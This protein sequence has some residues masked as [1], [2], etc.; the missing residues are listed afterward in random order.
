MGKIVITSGERYVDIDVLACAISYKDLL[1]QEGKDAIAVFPGTFNKSITNDIKE[2][3]V[4]YLKSCPDGVGGFVIVDM[5]NP[6][7]MAKCVIKDKIIQIYDHHFG[8]KEYWE[9]RL[10][11]N[12]V[13]EYVGSCATLIWE[14][15]KKRSNEDISEVNANLLSVAIVSNTLNFKASVTNERDRKALD[16]LKPHRALDDEWI[17]KYFK[18]QSEVVY[19]NPVREITNDSNLY[20][21]LEDF[22]V[23]TI[24]QIELWDSRKLV[25][26]Y[27]DEIEKALLSFGNRNWFMTAPSISEGKN[28]IFT[29]NNKIKDLLE[30]KISVEFDGDVGETKKLWLRKEILRELQ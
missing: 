28:Y 26:N 7:Y 21:E 10:G 22:K 14:E 1:R 2:W 15:Y 17:E 19:K 3:S 16:E 18:D 4:H 11:K 5:S 6:S 20:N 30:R 24:G 8:F 9:E 25:E 12:A 29:K 13:I 23:I 27:Q